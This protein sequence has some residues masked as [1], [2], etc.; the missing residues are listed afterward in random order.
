MPSSSGIP[1]RPTDMHVS[2]ASQY[3]AP[4]STASSADKPA[5]IAAKEMLFGSNP[6]FQVERDSIFFLLLCHC[7][8][9]FSPTKQSPEVWENIAFN[10]YSGDCFVVFFSFVEK[11]SSQ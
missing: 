7:E 4:S 6:C 1:P 9:D 8:E 3:L 5:F 10:H 11:D 2:A